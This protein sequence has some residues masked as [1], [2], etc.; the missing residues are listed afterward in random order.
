VGIPRSL[1]WLFVTGAIV[2]VLIGISYWALDLPN[3]VWAEE[4]PHCPHCRG[5]VAYYA[6]RCPACREPFDWV[7][8]PDDDSPWCV[9]C[10]TKAEVDAMIARAKA[11]GEPAA[12][13]RLSKGLSLSE[14]AARA[15]WKALEPGRCGWCGGTGKDLA[16][17]ASG[18]CPVCFG[19]QTC[20]GCDGDLRTHLGDER[21]GRD[22]ERLKRDLGPLRGDAY[23][24]EFRERSRAFLG[25]NAGT[26]EATQIG[27]DPASLPREEPPPP[28][29]PPPEGGHRNLRA[30]TPPPPTAAGTARGRIEAAMRAL[31][32]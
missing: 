30:G 20:I 15:W 17:G 29:P 23:W 3:A 27:I 28:P 18:D 12:V 4:R 25:R 1:G 22:R 24:K 10:G 13:A 32:E 6:R 21:A 31:G 26:L 5:D 8:S 2:A 14:G 9:A 16:E 11:L 19:A 7:A